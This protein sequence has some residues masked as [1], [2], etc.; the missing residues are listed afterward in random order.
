MSAR[1]GTKSI[2]MVRM[3]LMALAAA[4]LSS[5]AHA[6][7]WDPREGSKKRAEL[8]GRAQAAIADFRASDPTLKTY[9]D[10]AHGYAVLPKVTKGGAG[11]GGARGKGVLFRSGAPAMKVYM[12]QFSIG[13]Q[14]GGK[15]YSEIIFFRDARAYEAF[16]DDAF[17]FSAEAQAIAVREGAGARSSY[18]DGVAIFV[19]DKGGVMAEASVGGQRFEVE[20]LK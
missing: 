10:E 19:R 2:S 1:T 12:S 3:L 8:I 14:I 20:P 18:D 7:K 4:F 16:L 5:A 6:E 9:F 11:I 13:A 17:E 15:T